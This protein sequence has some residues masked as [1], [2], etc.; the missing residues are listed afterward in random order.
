MEREDVLEAALRD[1]LA[2]LNHL[3]HRMSGEQAL[4]ECSDLIERIE[5]LLWDGAK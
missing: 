5:A 4:I 2:P 1:T 3:L